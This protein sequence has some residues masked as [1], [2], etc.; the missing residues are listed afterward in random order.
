MLSFGYTLLLNDAVVACHIAG[1]DP[2]GGYLHSLAQG[3]ASLALDL[4][5]EFRPV[6]V[7]SV[8]NG[9]VLGGKVTPQGFDHPVDSDKG[10]RM[11]P[12]TLKLF[13][14]A[15]EKRMLTLARH[16]GLGRRVSFRTA[17]MTQARLLASVLAG[18]ADAYE[19]MAWR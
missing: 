10:C 5:E 12:E 14:A 8:V 11:S 4:M 9:L 6:V 16:P 13:L 15:Y 18:R 7:D 17:L 2:E 1:L 19:P 3:R